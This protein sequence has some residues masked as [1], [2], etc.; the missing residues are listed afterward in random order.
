MNCTCSQLSFEVH[1]MPV[2]Q[3][4]SILT[5]LLYKCQREIFSIFLKKKY[6]NGLPR[7]FICCKEH[8]DHDLAH[9]EPPPLI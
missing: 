3:F 6:K 2:A 1:N 7:P 9:L 5:F 4:F 8:S